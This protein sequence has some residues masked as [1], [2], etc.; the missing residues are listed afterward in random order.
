LQ[1]KD[2]AAG[3]ADDPRGNVEHSI[4]QGLGLG[5]GEVAVQQQRLRPD[6]EILGGK[7]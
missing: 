5:H 4:A 3:V 2:R 6:G 7:D 1:A